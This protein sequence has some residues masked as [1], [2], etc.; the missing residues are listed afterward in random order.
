MSCHSTFSQRGGLV[1]EPGKA[2]ASLVGV[3]ADNDR[4]KALG[5]KRVNPGKPDS[6]FLM[7]KLTGPGPGEGDRMPDGNNPLSEK[8]ITAIRTWIANGAKQD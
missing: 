7:I 5:L 2:Y 3:I 4:A 6:S 1:L 8:A